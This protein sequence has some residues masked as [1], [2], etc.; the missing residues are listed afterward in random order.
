MRKPATL[1][2]KSTLQILKRIVKNSKKMHPYAE[3]T[4]RQ[5]YEEGFFR[6]VIVNRHGLFVRY[7]SRHFCLGGNFC[8]SENH[9]SR[10]YLPERTTPTLKVVRNCY[11]TFNDLEKIDKKLA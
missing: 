1:T 6:E 11:L 10:F 9:N 2:E 5:G 4:L 3:L 8:S 7:S